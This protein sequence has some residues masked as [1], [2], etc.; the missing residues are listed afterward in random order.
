MGLIIS[1]LILLPV[2]VYFCIILFKKGEPLALVVL[3]GSII[4]YIRHLSLDALAGE[5]YYKN[6]GS[7]RLW[8]IECADGLFIFPIFVL[9]IALIYLVFFYLRCIIKIGANPYIGYFLTFLIILILSIKLLLIDNSLNGFTERQNISVCL[10]FLFILTAIIVFYFRSIKTYLKAESLFSEL[11]DNREKLN[12]LILLLSEKITSQRT[13]KWKYFLGRGRAYYG[14]EKYDLALIDL[15]KALEELLILNKLNTVNL[16]YS[17]LKVISNEYKK[18]M[19]IVFLTIGLTYHKL[20]NEFKGDLYLS[21][22]N[23]AA[24][25]SSK[26][27]KWYSHLDSRFEYDIEGSLIFFSGIIFIGFL[28][29]S[30]HDVPIVAKFEERSKILTGNKWFY[31][32]HSGTETYIGTYNFSEEDSIFNKTSIKIRS[33][34]FEDKRNNV[35]MLLNQY[36]IYSSITEQVFQLRGKFVLTNGGWDERVFQANDSKNTFHPLNTFPNC[37]MCYCE[38][39]SDTL[40]SKILRFNNNI[41][42]VRGKHNGVNFE[43]KMQNGFWSSMSVINI[44]D[45]PAW[46]VRLYRMLNDKII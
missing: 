13:D 17:N 7:L 34:S 18:S 42:L 26:F 25:K 10:H 4:F 30:R 41:I 11:N 43:L 40:S 27:K 1:A 9:I 33:K 29:F 2:S 3:L 39:N 8:T 20:K 22:A 38:Y 5:M 36:R 46:K 19:E 24:D 35:N 44:D 23:Y 31:T 12:N 6:G 28:Y 32:L 16:T 45:E 37:T 21:Y 14:L 15:N